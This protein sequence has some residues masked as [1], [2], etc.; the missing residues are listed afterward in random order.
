MNIK[1][2]LKA[3]FAVIVWGASFVATKLV[4]KAYPNLFA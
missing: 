1:A 2:I 4:E 3:I